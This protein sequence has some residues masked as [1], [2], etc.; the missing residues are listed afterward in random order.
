MGTTAV[1][2]V[3][4]LYDIHGNLPALEAALAAVESTGADGIVVGGDVV[5]GPMP[6]QTLD[7]LLALGDRARFIRGNCD[8]MVVEAFDGQPLTRWPPSIREPIAWTAGQLER[9][10][11]DFLASL[12][13]TLVLHVPGLGEVLFCHASP[14]SDEELFTA[15]TPA[16]RLRPM[17]EGLTQ[18]VVVCGHTHMQ[19]DRAV[20]GVRLVNAGSVGM[21]YEGTPG[22]YWAL[23]GPD[24]ELRRTEY[25]IEAAVAAIRA[26]GAPHVEKQLVRFLLE[27][28]DPTEA[29]EYFESLRGA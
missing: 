16:E 17:L 19:F 1:R 13:E 15:L 12:P 20:D 24:V 21:P 3:A 26:T 10:H 4:A 7:R 23:L 2:Q 8:R 14:R 9:R 5:L 11:R 25:D 29:T 22:A 27:P 18:P 6:R 28:P